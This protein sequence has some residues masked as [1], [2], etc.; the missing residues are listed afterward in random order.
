MENGID[1]MMK[2]YEKLDFF[3]FSTQPGTQACLFS[4]IKHGRKAIFERTNTNKSTL[5]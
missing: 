4:E 3:K 5:F 1:A 2:I